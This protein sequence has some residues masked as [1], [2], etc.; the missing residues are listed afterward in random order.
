MMYALTILTLTEGSRRMMESDPHGYALTLTS[1]CFVFGVLLLLFI[2][3]GKAKVRRKAADAPDEAIATAI[4]AALAIYMAESSH[5]KESGVITID[6][7]Y[8]SKW[9]TGPAV[10]QIKQPLSK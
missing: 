9:K 1:I 2:R 5:E 4:A 3:A 7:K 8:G 6:R 10:K